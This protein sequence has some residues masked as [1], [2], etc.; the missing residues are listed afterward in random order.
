M[1]F[2]ISA[3]QL[4]LAEVMG[5]RFHIV[6]VLGAGS[7]TPQ[8]KCLTDPVGLWRRGKADVVFVVR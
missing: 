2:F 1:G 8:I 3:R 5:P 4:T 6:R 7:A